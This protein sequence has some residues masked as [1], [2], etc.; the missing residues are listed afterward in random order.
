MGRG[1]QLLPGVVL[2]ACL[3]G[4]VTES[5]RPFAEGSDGEA[6]RSYLQL[7]AAYLQQGDMIN[8]RHHLDSAF[9]IDA[10]NSE[11]FGIQALLHSRQGDVA[12]ADESFRRALALDRGSS[13]VR[14]NYA[15]FLYA[16][17]RYQEAYEQLQP[18]V[19]DTG[20]RL[21][22]QAFE[23]LGFAALRL[24]RL[25]EAENAFGRALQLDA[26]LPRSNLELADLHLRRHDVQQASRYYGNYQ[27]LS[28]FFGEPVN[29][30]ALWVGIRLERALG[31]DRNVEE[32]AALLEQRFGDSEEF[33]LYLN[34]SDHE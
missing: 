30:R 34:D 14:N 1:G 20:Y 15:A 24:G 7:S 6:L 29:A 27:M 8:A 9:A 32:Y 21:R 16:H 26:Q 22:P 31:N 25:D 18:V 33:Q 12:L 13:Q 17:G 28:R 4:C 2:A 3:G 5:T 23:N 19:R 11:A 10:R